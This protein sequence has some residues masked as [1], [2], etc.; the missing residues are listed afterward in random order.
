MMERYAKLYFNDHIYIYRYDN[1]FRDHPLLGRYPEIRNLMMDYSDFLM[2]NLV[3]KDDD[4]QDKLIEFEQLID[5]TLNENELYK[6]FIVKLVKEYYPNWFI[7]QNI[8]SDELFV[9]ST[10]TFGARE[11]RNF[12]MEKRRV[13]M[14]IK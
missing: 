10:D 6:F 4:Y 13:K 11:V 2:K 5:V 7:V 14:K 1:S 3:D 12:N 9:V 8:N